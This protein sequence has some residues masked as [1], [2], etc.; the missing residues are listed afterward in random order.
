MSKTT[1]ETPIMTRNLL[2]FRLKNFSIYVMEHWIHQRIVELIKSG[3]IS[4]EK[5]CSR[6]GISPKTLYRRRKEGSW[7]LP[8]MIA[9]E[10]LYGETLVSVNVKYDQTGNGQ[11]LNDLSHTYDEA[12]SYRFK[13]EIDPDRFNPEDLNQLNNELTER[14]IEKYKRKNSDG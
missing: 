11:Y 3:R 7:T 14:L 6:L 12:P 5:V 8:E 2:S 9:I 4:N 13:I 1:K 10:E